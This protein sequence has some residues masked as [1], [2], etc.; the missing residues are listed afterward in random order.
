MESV[1]LIFGRSLSFLADR[2]QFRHSSEVV[3]D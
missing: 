2:L 3:S 1:P